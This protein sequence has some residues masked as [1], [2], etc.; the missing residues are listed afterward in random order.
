MIMINRYWIDHNAGCMLRDA[1][2]VA[3]YDEFVQ[4]TSLIRVS[5]NV[6]Y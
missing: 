2:A 4:R 1:Y 5:A 6:I 3:L